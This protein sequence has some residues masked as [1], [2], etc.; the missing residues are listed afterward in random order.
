MIDSL[1]NGILSLFAMDPKDL[2]LLELG[3]IP[4]T[5]EM[6]EKSVHKDN[7]CTIKPC[8]V[9]GSKD[10][11]SRRAFVEECFTGE[12]G[13]KLTYAEMRARYG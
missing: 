9:C 10:E 11:E 6:I 5:K 8:P 1:L 2:T 12:N 13:E 3:V 7:T 4:V